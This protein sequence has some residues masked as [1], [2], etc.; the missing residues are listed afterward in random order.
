MEDYIIKILSTAVIAVFSWIMAHYFTSEREVKN[1]QR[2]IK[3]EYLI[4]AY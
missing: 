2:E 1:K 3:V 4:E